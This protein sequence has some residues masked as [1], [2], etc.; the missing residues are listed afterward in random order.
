MAEGDRERLIDRQ[1]P[2][3]ETETG[4]D[5]GKGREIKDRFGLFSFKKNLGL[6]TVIEICIDIQIGIE[7]EEIILR[8]REREK[9]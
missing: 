9:E 8:D 4:T 1:R 6:N 7:V 5:I 2:E 3:T